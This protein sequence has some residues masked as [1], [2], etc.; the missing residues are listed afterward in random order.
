MKILD[1]DY[2]TPK[3]EEVLAMTTAM[4]GTKPGEKLNLYFTFECRNSVNLFSTHIGLKTL[5]I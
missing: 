1:P 5:S 3:K 4:A 2:L